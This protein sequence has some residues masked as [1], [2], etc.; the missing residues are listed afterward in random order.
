[1]Q[2]KELETVTSIEQN[3]Q[4]DASERMPYQAPC[5]VRLELKNTEAGASG[6]TDGGIFS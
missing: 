3:E 1:M 4:I 6:T 2:S 5:L